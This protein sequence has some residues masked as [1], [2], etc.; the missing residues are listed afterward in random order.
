M[1]SYDSTEYAACNYIH[2]PSEKPPQPQTQERLLNLNRVSCD[3]PDGMRIITG[4]PNHR[5]LEKAS[6]NIQYV[7]EGEEKIV[8]LKKAKTGFGFSLK[9]GKD[10]PQG[11]TPLTIKKIFTGG[12]AH[13]NGS[14]RI[15]DEI[16]MVNGMDC[17][18]LSRVEVWNFMKKLDQGATN[19]WIRRR[20]VD[21]G[22]IQSD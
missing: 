6:K 10:S 4:H 9:G 8:V 17:T 3:E 12:S 18:K 5:I 14:L 2:M 20:I 11:D 21:A 15:G 13:R 7:H 19:F 16:I 1:R 22:D